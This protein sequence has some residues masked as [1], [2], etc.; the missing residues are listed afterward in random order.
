MNNLS[1]AAT[2]LYHSGKQPD[3]PVVTTAPT[4]I[5]DYRR[6][7]ARQDSIKVARRSDELDPTVTHSGY[8]AGGR[9][10]TKVLLPRTNE[11]ARMARP[12]SFLPF[13]L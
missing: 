10:P 2:A 9:T 4:I 13:F 6:S 11:P 8:G 7:P 1:D 3:A 5:R 12:N